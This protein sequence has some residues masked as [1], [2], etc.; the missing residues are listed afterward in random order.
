[1]LL[2][3]L[4]IDEYDHGVCQIFYA[5]LFLKSIATSC[6]FYT[7]PTY[8]LGMY[9]GLQKTDHTNVNGL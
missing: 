4:C 5:L 7:V 8:C 9:R 2:S 6:K 1:M 3:K